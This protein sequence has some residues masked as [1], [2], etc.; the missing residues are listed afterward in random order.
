MEFQLIA[1]ISLENSYKVEAVINRS[2]TAV[3]SRTLLALVILKDL[4]P[5]AEYNVKILNCA[6]LDLPG[7][8]TAKTVHESLLS[9]RLP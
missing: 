2:A 5:I 8:L 6:Y 3:I 1:L 7:I 4:I 9:K